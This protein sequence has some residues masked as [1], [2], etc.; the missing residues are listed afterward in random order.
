[1]RRRIYCDPETGF[2]DCTARP[3]VW[4]FAE[5]NTNPE[6]PSV[7]RNEELWA[8]Y[9]RAEAVLAEV[10]GRVASALIEEPWDEVEHR[11]GNE[12]RAVMDADSVSGYAHPIDRID[13]IEDELAE[14]AKAAP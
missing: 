9:E 11:L 2:E 13:E 7:L 4:G 8:E 5:W 6:P 3:S 14:N 1:M 10:S 12:H